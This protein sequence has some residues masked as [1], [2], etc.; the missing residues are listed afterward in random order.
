MKLKISQRFINILLFSMIIGLFV[1]VHMNRIDIHNLKS[2]IL[3]MEKIII[4]PFRNL[5]G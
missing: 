5:I 1:Y 4:D 2:A 3:L